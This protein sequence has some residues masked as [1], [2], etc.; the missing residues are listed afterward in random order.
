[1][2][3]FTLLKATLKDLYVGNISKVALTRTVLCSE[4]KGKG[5]KEDAVKTCGGCKGQG[6]KF[7]TRQMGPMLQR[8]Q[9][10]CNECNGEGT[11]IDAKNRCKTCKGKK[12]YE[13][14]KILEVHIDKGMA[15][16]QK[17][18]FA[19]EGDQGPGITPGDVVFVVDEQPHEHFRRKGDD[20]YYTAK[21]DLLT[22]LAG[23]K[24]TI[25]THVDGEILIVEIIPG[26][27]IK[28]GAVKVINGKGMPTFRHHNYGNMYVE[29]DVEFPAAE[30]FATPETSR[31]WRRFCL[32]EPE[33]N[34]PAGAVTDRSDPRW[35]WSEQV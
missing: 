31:S 32:L 6:V 24:F 34:I 27:V 30:T 35:R 29:F 16:G 9:T 7:V 33:V 4:C 18:T 5:G 23:G 15:N 8:F 20:L 11:I 26:E 17:I 1:M 28:H 21:I 2:I 14:R 19:G 12:T 13:E 10:V 25:I 22:A 3:L